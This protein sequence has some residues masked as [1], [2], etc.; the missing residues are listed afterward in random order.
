M[1]RSAGCV[2]AAAALGLLAVLGAACGGDEAAPEVAPPASSAA[3]VVAAT[4]TTSAWHVVGLGDSYMSAQNAQGQGFMDLFGSALQSATGHAVEVDAMTDDANTTT[5]LLNKLQTDEATRTA[6]GN[7][8]VVVISVG[9]NDSDPFGVF[10]KGTCTPEQAL[11]DCLKAYAPTYAANYEQILS[12]IEALRAGRPTAIRV[13]SADNPFVG[14]SEAPS[15]TFGR[16][17]Y[18]QVAEAETAAA[19]SAAE[20][21]GGK[22]VDY[23]H[24][25]SGADGG[26][27][28]APYLADDHAHPGDKGIETIAGLLTD[29]GVPELT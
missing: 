1:R 16:D 20:Q 8:D 24:V 4:T 29:L 7:A 15:D 26:E 27:D 2:R 14:W 19:C 13:T 5:R 9:G 3:S 25:F 28:P 12:E 10:P 21:H 11:A 17:F 6:V 22:C 23:L 18:A